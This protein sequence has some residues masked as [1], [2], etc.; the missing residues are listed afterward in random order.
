MLLQE[1]VSAHYG[2]SLYSMTDP[3]YM[4]VLIENLGASNRVGQDGQGR[5][6][7]HGRGQDDSGYSQWERSFLCQ[8]CGTLAVQE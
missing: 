7:V 6:D 3:L 2:G 8:R 5:A 1:V 4:L